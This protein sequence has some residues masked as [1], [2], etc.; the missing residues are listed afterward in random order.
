MNNEE[1]VRVIPII[2]WNLF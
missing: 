1:R 2:H